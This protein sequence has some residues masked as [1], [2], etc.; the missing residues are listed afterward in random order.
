MPIRGILF[1]NDGT[2]VDTHDLILASF[3][4]A[5]RTVLGRDFP[6]SVLMAKVGI[7][8]DDQMRDYSD[9]P[10]TQA[11][12]SRVYREHNHAHHDQEIAL[13]PGVGE[14]LARL[15][16][17]GMAM[18]V[19]TAKRHELAWHGLDILG[20]AV[21]LRCLV[22]C[23]DCATSKPDPAPVLM[24]C[25]LLDLAP[26]ECLY[27][28]DSPYDIQAGNAA[29]CPTVAVL[30]GMFGEDVLRAEDPTHV[31]RSFDELDALCR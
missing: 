2:L 26:A 18:G 5:V 28:G 29:G 8:L 15:D 30:W 19:V 6:D 4:H 9:D 27:V 25:E 16:A 3:H 31:I 7:P 14:G 24:A 10:A 21:H 12:L 1:D 13:F 20:A 17:S 22:G 23:D 11:E